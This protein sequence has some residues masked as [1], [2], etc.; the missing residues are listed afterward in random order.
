MSGNVVHRV[1]VTDRGLEDDE[2]PF[3]L[4]FAETAL[5][6]GGYLLAFAEPGVE[7]GIVLVD[8]A[9]AT[10]E[11]V[12]DSAV[13]QARPF[14]SIDGEF[15]AA[16]A[17]QDGRMVIW[18]RNLV[19]GNNAETDLGEVAPTDLRWLPDGAG[20]SYVAGGQATVFEIG[21]GERTLALDDRYEV[22]EVAF[23]PDG[24][25][26]ALVRVEKPPEPT[27]TPTPSETPAGTPTETPTLAGTATPTPVDTPVR[28]GVPE[29]KWL[30]DIVLRDGERL[31]GVAAGF[32]EISK[33]RWIRAADSTL[34]FVGTSL[35]GVSGLWMLTPG[36]IPTL[37]YEGRVDDATWSHDGAYVAVVADGGPCGN[38]TC[39][40]GFLRVVELATAAVYGLDTARVVGAPAWERPLNGP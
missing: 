34:A 25:R 12:S 11:D 29:P 18:W 28:T 9:N 5:S 35:Q 33:L 24:T 23:A 37:V 31:A 30:V 19:S 32:T 1:A 13:S 10:Q 20:F 38:R 39:P 40:R 22:R 14:W 6:P 27:A 16:R 36:F 26:A 8:L 15:V 21:V 2:L 4:P 17:P 7:S 3:A